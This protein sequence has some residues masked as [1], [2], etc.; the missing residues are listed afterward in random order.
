MAT[1]TTITQPQR[2]TVILKNNEALESLIDMVFT[3]TNLG[4]EYLFSYDRERPTA[5]ATAIAHIRKALQ[6]QMMQTYCM[7]LEQ[8]I[9]WLKA[10]KEWIP[11]NRNETIIKKMFNSAPISKDD[12]Q[13]FKEEFL[14]NK[15]DFIKPFIFNV[16][17]ADLPSIEKQLIEA[18]E[19]MF[20]TIPFEST[21]Q[22]GHILKRTYNKTKHGLLMFHKKDYVDPFV[23]DKVTQISK[24]ETEV[25]PLFVTGKRDYIELLNLSMAAAAPPCVKIISII[26]N[27]LFGNLPTPLKEVVTGIAPT[28]KNVQRKLLDLNKKIATHGFN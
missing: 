28:E 27:Q 26:Y 1:Q 4:G 7:F 9:G 22:V 13:N 10:L 15:Q 16:P 14:K 18:F 2:N 21:N 19:N 24:E 20:E 3:Y 5:D 6:I 23:T 12:I 11:S 17:A 8:V 25:L